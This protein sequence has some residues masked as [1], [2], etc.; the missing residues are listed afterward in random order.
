MNARG[1]NIVK[2]NRYLKLQ[3]PH[4]APLKETGEEVLLSTITIRF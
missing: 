4:L 1:Q 3:T 2:L